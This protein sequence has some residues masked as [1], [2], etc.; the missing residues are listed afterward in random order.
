M[1]GGRGEGNDKFNRAVY[2]LRQPGSAIKPFLY[3]VALQKGFTP[4]TIIVDEP[5]E[6]K[7]PDGTVWNV[8]NYHEDYQ[9]P[10]TLRRAVELSTN[11]VAVKVLEQVG[12]KDTIEMAKKMGISTLVETGPRNDVG[13]APMAL[14]GLTRGVSPLEMA[15][16]FAVFANQGIRVEPIAITKVVDANGNVLEENKPRR[17]VVLDEEV[18]YMMTDLLRGVIERG[19]AKQANIGRPAAGKTGTSQDWTNGWFIGYTPDLVASI[20][21][22]NDNQ[23]ERMIYKGVRYGSWNAAQMW[24]DF[25]R[26]ALKGTPITNFPKPD[27]IVEGVLIDTKTGLLAKENAGI[28]ADELAYE[29]FIAGTE[30]TEWSPRM[31]TSPCGKARNF[32]QG[33]WEQLVNGSEGK[34]TPQESEKEPPSALED[35]SGVDTTPQDGEMSLPEGYYYYQEGDI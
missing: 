32:F 6:Y 35:D 26:Q 24:G 29:T 5:L 21:I 27:K 13:L 28:P 23:A 19:T 25:M 34:K 3:T 22:G 33:V 12:I 20:W 10:M 2:A 30:P 11:V 8:S 18:A 9:G 16:S 1:V 4:A 17:Q 31:V 15:A 14:G 7:M